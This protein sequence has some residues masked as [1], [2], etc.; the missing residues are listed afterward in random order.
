MLLAE[1]DGGLRC[2]WCSRDLELW[3]RREILELPKDEQ[4]AVFEDAATLDHVIPVSKGGS[5][6]LDNLIIA[7]RSC[8][9]RRKA[10]NIKQAV[11]FFLDLGQDVQ[12]EVVRAARKRANANPFSLR[13]TI[14]KAI[15]CR[16]CGFTMPMDV[17]SKEPVPQLHTCGK[18][19]GHAMAIQSV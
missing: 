2:A 8:N 7:C 6:A 16:R 4:E 3:E 15:K 9:G 13:A 17:A 11:R 1:R 14:T 19:G 5:R 18:H 12:R 10:M